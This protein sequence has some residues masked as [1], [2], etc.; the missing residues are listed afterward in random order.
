[1]SRNKW[2]KNKGVPAHYRN[3]KVCEMKKEPEPIEFTEQDNKNITPIDRDWETFI[4]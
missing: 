1:M 3:R 4:L 2:L